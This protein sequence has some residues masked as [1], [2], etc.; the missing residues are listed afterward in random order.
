MMDLE[1][2]IFQDIT[3]NMLIDINRFG[4]LKNLI[5]TYKYSNNLIKMK[6]YLYTVCYYL[7]ELLLNAQNAEIVTDFLNDYKEYYNLLEKHADTVKKTLCIDDLLMMPIPL[8]RQTNAPPPE[9][10]HHEAIVSFKMRLS[11]C[12]HLQH[13]MLYTIEYHL[14]KLSVEMNYTQKMI[15]KLDI[16]RG[17]KQVNNPIDIMI[18]EMRVKYVEMNK[19]MME[20]Y[21]MKSG[22]LHDSTF[23]FEP[24]QEYSIRTAIYTYYINLCTIYPYGLPSSV[25]VDCYGKPG[26]WEKLCKE[27]CFMTGKTLPCP[28]PRTVV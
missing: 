27:K 20:F 8:E 17:G 25:I 21:R 5:Y 1:T 13:S 2:Y 12:T 22:I 26:L 16:V 23:T 14:D 10:P 18:N 4:E 7:E 24:S 3:P 19:K 28:K 15:L 11:D 6:N 9:E